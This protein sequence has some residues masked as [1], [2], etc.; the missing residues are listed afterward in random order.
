MLPRQVR[1]VAVIYADWQ[2]AAAPD[3][4]KLLKEAIRNQ[5][6]ALLVD[7]V[8]KDIGN[9]FCHAGAAQLAD[10][11]RAA[12]GSKMLTVLAGSLRLDDLDVALALEPDYVAVRGAVC[13]NSRQHDLCPTKLADWSRRLASRSRASGTR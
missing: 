8:R 12:R 2:D 4:E 9:V 1:P 6:R 11:F 3:P 7:T 5:C 10:W 13:R